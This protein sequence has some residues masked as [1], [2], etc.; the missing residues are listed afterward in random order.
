MMKIIINLKII[1]KLINKIGKL[2]I[3]KYNKI[4]YIYFSLLF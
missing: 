3:K 1:Q 2:N 4:I